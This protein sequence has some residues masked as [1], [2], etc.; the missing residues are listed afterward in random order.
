MIDYDIDELLS[1][2]DSI[3]PTDLSRSE[4]EKL[5]TIAQ[6]LRD[7]KWVS[8]EDDLPITFPSTYMCRMSEK[9]LVRGV[10]KDQY[11]WV[12][13]LHVDEGEKYKT[14]AHGFDK[15][16]VRYTWLSPYRDIY[17]NQR[18]TE[19]MPLPGLSK[20]SGGE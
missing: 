7:S 19:W 13:H 9:V 15:D 11:P 5:R 2:L 1:W 8:V 12:A 4:Q 10:G 20:Q 6:I 18:I 17:E 3:A 16:G 14:Y